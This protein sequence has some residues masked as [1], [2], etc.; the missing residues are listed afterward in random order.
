MKQ[1]LRP[2]AWVLVGLNI[3]LIGVGLALQLISGYPMFGVPMVVHFSESIALAGF[4]VVGALI[5]SQHPGHLVGWFWLLMAVS[6]GGD[7]FA[8]G[9]TA[10]GTTA[11]PA[12]LPGV[13]VSVFW[14]EAL[15]RRS[16]GFLAFTLLLLLFPILF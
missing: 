3:I 4:A 6:F 13:S 10:Y 8:W 11:T 15:G 16:I 14:L 7:H 1:F 9:Y 5:V 12:A 2:L